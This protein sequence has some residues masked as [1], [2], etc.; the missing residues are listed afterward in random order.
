MAPEPGLR[1]DIAS[2]QIAF[3]SV[4]LPEAFAP[5]TAATLSEES[6]HV[7]PF[8]GT[9]VRSELD[10]RSSVARSQK[11]RKPENSN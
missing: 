10:A 4:V 9:L 8:L 2:A 1:M 5:N 3:S 11:D 6:A 7:T